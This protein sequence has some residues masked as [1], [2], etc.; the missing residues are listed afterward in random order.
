M[1]Q[2]CKYGAPSQCQLNHQANLRMDGVNSCSLKGPGVRLMKTANP[3]LEIQPTVN[4]TKAPNEYTVVVNFYFPGRRPSWLGSQDTKVSPTGGKCY[5][6]T[7][8]FYL[9]I[10]LMLCDSNF[11]SLCTHP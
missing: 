1:G 4:E 11:F 10:V 6:E 2:S 7:Q 5:E 8:A 3:N 9:G